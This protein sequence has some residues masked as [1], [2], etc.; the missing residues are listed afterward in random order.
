[1]QDTSSTSIA[2]EADT[3]QPDRFNW[4]GLWIVFAAFFSLN[5]CVGGVIGFNKYRSTEY[6]AALLAQDVHFREI[7]GSY[8]LFYVSADSEVISYNID[9]DQISMSAG[10]DFSSS[11]MPSAPPTFVLDRP[12]KI[13]LELVGSG[14]VVYSL[15]RL[16]KSASTLSNMHLPTSST[17]W[18][19]VARKGS[20][21]IAA[22]V[23]LVS[24]YFLGDWV[25]AELGRST[26]KDYRNQRWFRGQVQ[27]SETWDATKRIVYLGLAAQL[28]E[29]RAAEVRRVLARSC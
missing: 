11:K 15:P 18:W 12:G 25:G 1:M 2:A 6:A 9:S 4:K 17:G 8:R 27:K 5:F 28:A 3:G 7:S 19:G 24:G 22:A 23:G 26:A 13:V 20:P 29:Y 14:A 16:Y 21:V 10:A